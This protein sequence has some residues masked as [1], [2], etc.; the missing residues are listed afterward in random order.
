MVMCNASAV[1]HDMR[2]LALLLLKSDKITFKPTIL[3]SKGFVKRCFYYYGEARALTTEKTQVSSFPFCSLS[4][5]TTLTN[6]SEILVGSH[7]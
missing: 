4:S 7:C 3:L 2:R 1:G 5:C 6:A